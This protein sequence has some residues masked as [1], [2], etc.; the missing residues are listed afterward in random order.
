[1]TQAFDDKRAV[2]DAKYRADAP[3]RFDHP[4]EA[5][6]HCEQLAMRDRRVAAKAEADA[7]WW[8]D[9]RDQALATAR[10]EVKPGDN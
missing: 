9:K 6:L 8:L 7:Q 10:K 5:A 4:L 3:W 1:M 2:M